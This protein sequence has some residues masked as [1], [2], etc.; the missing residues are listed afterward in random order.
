MLRSGR[1]GLQELYSAEAAI[2]TGDEGGAIQSEK[3][4]CDVNVIMARFFTTGAAPA[5]RAG[6]YADVTTVPDL[7]GALDAAIRVREAF[8]LLP[9]DVRDRFQNDPV[10]LAE[11][12]A[13]RRNDAEAVRL[14]LREAPVRAPVDA[15]PAV[16]EAATP[17]G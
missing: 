13:D 1:D 10:R 8:G 6:Y 4:N 12:L 15:T 16:A 2:D 7:R 9:A 17:S 14:G 3:V 11:W 5:L